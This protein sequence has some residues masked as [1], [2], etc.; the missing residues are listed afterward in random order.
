MPNSSAY[1]AMRYQNEGMLTRKP[2]HNT[3]SFHETSMSQQFIH[4]CVRTCLSRYLLLAPPYCWT[5][6]QRRLLLCESTC[7]STIRLPCNYGEPLN[8][9]NRTICG[10]A[11]SQVRRVPTSVKLHSA[12][13]LFFC[14][15]AWSKS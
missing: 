1:Y 10:R 5:C 9:H 15:L 8:A 6:P 2:W 13:V 11:I 12:H 3:A 4:I 7:S 14:A